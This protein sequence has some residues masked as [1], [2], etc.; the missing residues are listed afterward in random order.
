MKKLLP[1]LGIFLLYLNCQNDDDSNELANVPEE[2]CEMQFDDLGLT[3]AHAIVIP[4]QHEYPS[5]INDNTSWMVKYS[6]NI[7][8]LSYERGYS[9]ENHGNVV[10]VFKKINDCIKY[11]YRY[12][13]V[14]GG[15]HPIN[16]VYEYFI[17]HDLIIQEYIPDEKL[18]GRLIGEYDSEIH[19]IDFWIDFTTDDFFVEEVPNYISFQNCL[20]NQLPMNI[21][22]N[23]DGVDDF[24][25]TR[26][27]QMYENTAFPEIVP[28]LR[29]AVY[30]ET[31]S[32]NNAILAGFENNSL[33]VFTEQLDEN[34]SETNLVV[35]HAD[36]IH[37]NNYP[38]KQFNFWAR[39]SNWEPYL[40]STLTNFHYAIKMIVNGEPHYGYVKFSLSG[41]DCEIIIHE[42]YLNPTPNE[43][44][45]IE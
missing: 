33:P 45:I 26:D 6:E 32:N 40:Y 16:G 44:I 17:E 12:E 10:Y 24:R 34:G 3:E 36:F 14:M 41:I 35:W 30:F 25:F 1:L 37:E 18:V 15:I 4:E 5:D 39:Y 13:V 8:E 22:I 38:Y 11:D 29:N 21:D 31:I 9:P 43:H 28:E 20:G 7:V 23:N 2:T 27:E 42:T 19:N